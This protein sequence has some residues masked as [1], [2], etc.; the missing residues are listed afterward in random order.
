MTGN[1][2]STPY[3]TTMNGVILKHLDEIKQRTAASVS[4]PV[5]WKKRLRDFLSKKNTELLDFLTV[6]TA[7]HSTLSKGDLLMKKFGASYVQPNHASVREYVLDVSGENVVAELTKRLEE[8]RTE[9]GLKDYLASVR[10]LFDQYRE[11]GEQALAKEAELKAKLEVLDKVQGRLS[12]VLDLDPNERYA[13]LMEATEGYLESLYS[14]H[15][16]EDTYKE[17]IAAYRRFVALRDVILMTRTIQSNENEPLCTIC[18]T[19]PV[20]FTLTPCGHTF[21]GTCVRRQVGTCF[22]CRGPFREKV[23]L[24][25]G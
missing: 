21:C 12:A 9:D 2:S 17:L 8:L 14:K 16:I 19:E 15:A 6:S 3:T 10:F 25:F 11:A 13:P 23:K 7:S 20:S 1:G 5:G 22:V 4:L 18:L 24:F